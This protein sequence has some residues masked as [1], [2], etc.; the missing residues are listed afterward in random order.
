MSIFIL[1]GQFVLL[2]VFLLLFF[3]FCL[4][5]HWFLLSLGLWG[6]LGVGW[7]LLGVLGR[8]GWLLLGLGLGFLVGGYY[9]FG[10]WLDVFVLV[11]LLRLL[12]ILLVRLTRFW[13]NFTRLTTI[14]NIIINILQALQITSTFFLLNLFTIILTFLFLLILVFHRF[15]FLLFCVGTINR[16]YDVLVISISI[17]MGWFSFILFWG[18]FFLFDLF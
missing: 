8:L 2:L 10:V 16:I 5:V 17:S 9:W 15:S 18:Y 14:P 7:F 11:R 13:F 12:G 3:A 1:L 6:F 4:L